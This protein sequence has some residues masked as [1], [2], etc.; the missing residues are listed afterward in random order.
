MKYCYMIHLYIK[1]NSIYE[2][3][4]VPDVVTPIQ[5]LTDILSVFC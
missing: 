2:S 3:G 5:L 4:T 1:R